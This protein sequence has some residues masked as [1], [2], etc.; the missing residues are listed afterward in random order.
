MMHGSRSGGASRVYR[1]LSSFHGGSSFTWLYASS[2]SLDRPHAQ[3]GAARVG[4]D[5]R[6]IGDGSICRYWPGSAV[7]TRQT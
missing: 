5:E 4:A 3:A 7:P 1:G 6:K 2:Q